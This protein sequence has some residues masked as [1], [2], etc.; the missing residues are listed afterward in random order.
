MLQPFIIGGV[1]RDVNPT[2][3]AIERVCDLDGELT[4]T[5]KDK[6]GKMRQPFDVI[7]E[8]I[9]ILL[10]EPIKEL[11]RVILYHEIV[12]INKQINAYVK[13]PTGEPEGKH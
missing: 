11:R 13:N 2:Y 10:K 5:G 6:S 7:M 8:Q 12:A 3:D 4:N 1:E 9:N